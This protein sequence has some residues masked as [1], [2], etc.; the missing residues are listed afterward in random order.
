MLVK[1]VKTSYI[2][3]S[4]NI[5]S[6]WKTDSEPYKLVKIFFYQDLYIIQHQI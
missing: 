4:M 6:C 3:E 5:T 2:W 1:K